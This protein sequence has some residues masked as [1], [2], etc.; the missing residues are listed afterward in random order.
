MTRIT[1]AVDAM[2][3]DGGC[4]ITVPAV[5][6]LLA[7]HADVR[8]CLVG[9]LDAM[10]AALTEHG[11]A[12]HA[13]LELLAAAEVV[14]GSDSV[15]VALRQKK[16][17]SMRLAI[18]QVKD[19]RAQAVVS[20]GNTGALMAIAR[21]VLKTLPGIE[22]PAICT[23]IP[24]RDGVCHM[25]DLG[26]NVDV[27]AEHLVQFAL[28]GNALAGVEGH[29][30]P[31][32][33]LLNIG[34]EEIKGNDTIKQAAA[35]LALLDINYVGFV[36]GDGVFRGEADVVVCDG[37]VGNVALKTMEGVARLV[38]DFLK[39][40]AR[41]NLFYKLSALCALPLL[42]A[43][44]GRL[45]PDAYNGASLVGLNGIVVK[46]HGGTSVAGFTNALE[47]ALREARRDL[48]ALI[49][50]AMADDG[51]LHTLNTQAKSDTE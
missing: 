31:R 38:G 10:Q 27:E 23:A 50:R 15:A 42:N 41:R 21:F 29:A 8:V 13:R 26:A 51:V 18:N 44:K 47:V 5:A 7:A 3:G 9:L 4:A 37:F 43:L 14:K 34:A 19:G 17:S 2:G 24:T 33:A 16:Q 12:Q 39:Q 28:M 49:A 11:L 6:Q 32:V 45:N 30:Q 25:L 40:A 48:P 36:E 46:S 1:L 20:A 35:R 22:R